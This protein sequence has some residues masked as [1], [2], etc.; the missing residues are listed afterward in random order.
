MNQTDGSVLQPVRGIL[1]W[2]ATLLLVAMIDLY[3]LVHGN[4][5]LFLVLLLA[6]DVAMVGYV[7]DTK[8]GAWCYNAS[9]TFVAPLLLAAVGLK[10]PV[11]LPF[12]IVWAA[13][14]ALDRALGYG[15]K[16]DDSFTHTHLGQIGRKGNIH[17]AR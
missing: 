9:H 7:R 3:R 17:E 2:E 8:I 15:L 4:W 6:P 13:H 1:Q 10:F 16:Y 12:A 11:V 5:L 14:I